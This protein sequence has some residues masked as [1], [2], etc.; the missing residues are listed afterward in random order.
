MKE[1]RERADGVPERP[2]HLPDSREDQRTEP[3]SATLAD[4][5]ER[6]ILRLLDDRDQLAEQ[7]T[8]RRVRAAQSVKPAVSAETPRSPP[9][10]S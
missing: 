1:D 7:R 3:G 6:V 4:G 10:G 2:G 5:L 9:C 8:R